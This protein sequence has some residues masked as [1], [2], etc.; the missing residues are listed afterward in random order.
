MNADVT[1]MHAQTN[2]QLTFR[3]FSELPYAAVGSTVLKMEAFELKI[4]AKIDQHHPAFANSGSSLWLIQKM[5]LIIV[6]TCFTYGPEPTVA[7]NK[8]TAGILYAAVILH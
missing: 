2:A 4:A 1:F 6:P 3:A 8:P 7:H 5:M